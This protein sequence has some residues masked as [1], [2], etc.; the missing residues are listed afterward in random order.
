VRLRRDLD[1][2]ASDLR[3]LARTSLLSG[4][5][6]EA[7]LRLEPKKLSWRIAAVDHIKKTPTEN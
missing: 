4:G 7:G 5:A 3:V 1:G 2:E 6:G